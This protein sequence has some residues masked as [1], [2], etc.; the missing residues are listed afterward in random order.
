MVIFLLMGIG[1][2]PE[3]AARCALPQGKDLASGLNQGKLLRVLGGHYLRHSPS[4]YQWVIDDR[5]ARLQEVKDELKR[6]RLIGELSLAYVHLKQ[7][8][9][10]ESAV[11]GIGELRYQ[12]NLKLANIFMLADEFAKAHRAFGRAFEIN[13]NGRFLKEGY[14]KRLL[15]Y[16]AQ[17]R[18]RGRA[19]VPIATVSE[20]GK[21]TGGF[22]NFM[23][24]ASEHTGLDWRAS[25]WKL[26][27][28]ALVDYILCGH[29]SSPILWE[30]VGDLLRT[31]PK[32][33]R[34]N[35]AA[36]ATRSYLN[37]SYLTDSLWGR[38]EYRRLARGLV[39]PSTKKSLRK[40]ESRYGKERTKGKKLMKR[41]KRDE[42]R[43][44]R[45]KKNL[46][47]QFEKSYL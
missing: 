41:I 27:L 36:L 8:G 42:K 26:A 31:A 46:D 2:A 38:M 7:H 18:G 9:K 32:S 24:E 19:K 29:Q 44:L 43:W 3:A 37:A 35:S 4:Y 13:P 11:R 39:R 5:E 12:D 33:F 22:A 16:V 15:D 34:G 6:S 20:R 40:F 30:A 10:A 17:E 25:Q 1:Y 28:G 21:R 14:A 47:R 23:K 45:G